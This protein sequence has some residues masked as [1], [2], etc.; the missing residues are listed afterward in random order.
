MEEQV[1]KKYKKLKE[2]YSLPDIG[3]ISSFFGIYKIEEEDFLLMQIRKKIVEKF[4]RI[5]ETLESFIHPDTTI[6]DI[7]ECKAF[8]NDD[9][10]EIFKLYKRL[11]L[12]EKRSMELSFESTEEEE[13]EFI[14]QTL[15]LWNEVKEKMMHFIKKLKEFWKS[16]SPE[17]TME[18]YFG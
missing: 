4:I 2:K 1:I 8:S 7:Y 18:G 17:K 13:A 6:S 9:R 10:D 15:L 5:S 11:K 3:E 12:I 14:K 16:E